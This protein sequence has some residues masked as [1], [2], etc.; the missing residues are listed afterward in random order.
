MAKCR[1]KSCD[2]RGIDTDIL[3]APN[4]FEEGE[5]LYACPVCKSIDNYD[6]ICNHEG[7]KNVAYYYD[8]NTDNMPSYC[9]THRK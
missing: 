1:C 6:V 8:T 3:V 9:W 2:W 4:P 7:C 5:F